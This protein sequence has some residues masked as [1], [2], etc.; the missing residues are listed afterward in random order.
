MHDFRGVG[1]LIKDSA[2]VVRGLP[3]EPELELGNHADVKLPAAQTPEQLG[4]AAGND[5]RDRAVGTHH[6]CPQHVI[7]SKTVP[8]AE[9]AHT[10]A[11]RVSDDSD[12]SP[13]SAQRHHPVTTP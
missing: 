11:E 12:G 10:T 3:H 8:T 4:F 1:T 7:R 5:F 13:G 9:R 6:L 2:A